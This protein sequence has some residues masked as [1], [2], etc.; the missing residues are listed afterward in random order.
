MKRVLGVALLASLAVGVLVGCGSQSTGDDPSVGA[1]THSAGGIGVT[2]DKVEGRWLNPDGHDGP[3]G[4][5]VA[6]MKKD[7]KIEGFE[8]VLGGSGTEACAPDID[9]AVVA[10]SMLT[11][12]LK[13]TDP[14]VA[15]TKDLRPYNFQFT[16]AGADNIDEVFVDFNNNVGT[17]T[18][19]HR[20]DFIE[21]PGD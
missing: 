6:L 19:F 20:E 14:D 3:L 1:S 17:A 16:F 15:C 9:Q 10:D 8:L 5:A 13:A 4:D 11:V 21:L 7:G 2:V 18:A 12:T